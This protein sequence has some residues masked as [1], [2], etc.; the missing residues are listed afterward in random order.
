MP[1]IVNMSYACAGAVVQTAAADN[2]NGM[3]E[4]IKL[5]VD[6]RAWLSICGNALN[7]NLPRASES[8]PVGQFPRAATFSL[9]GV[10]VHTLLYTYY[11]YYV[12]KY[13]TE[14]QSIGT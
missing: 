12:H 1:T 14:L 3:R 13:N 5:P 2:S 4:C 8:F 11:I 7:E 9:S 6:P 10:R